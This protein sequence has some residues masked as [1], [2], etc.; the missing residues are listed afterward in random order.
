MKFSRLDADLR[1]GP[2]TASTP[3]AGGWPRATDARP[4][5]PATVAASF[6]PQYGPVTVD[7]VED[8]DPPGIAARTTDL[9]IAGFSFT[10]EARTVIAR[11]RT[12]TAYPHGPH[13]PGREPRHERAA[14]GAARAPIV[15]RV[16]PTR[17]QSSRSGPRTVPSRSRWRA[18]TSTIPVTTRS[19]PTRADK[20]AAWFLDGDYDGRTFC[21]TQAFFP[22]SSGLGQACKALGGA[23]DES[24]LRRWRVQCHCRSPPEAQGRGGQGDRPAR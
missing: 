21:I 24:A 23:V 16:R 3:R 6:G 12:R 4:R 20:V 19:T 1:R 5:G 2:P 8:P 17:G 13:P 22:D 9:L 18:W 15:L 14:Q 11:T 7:A 10:A